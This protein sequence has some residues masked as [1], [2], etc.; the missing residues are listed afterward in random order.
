LLAWAT[1]PI[2]SLLSKA[3]ANV[4]RSS[5]A[6]KLDAR[7]GDV[8]PA[9][10]L[11]SPERSAAPSLPSEPPP[12]IETAEE[13]Q[14]KHD[15]IV[16]IVEYLL[17]ACLAQDRL[18]HAIGYKAAGD[19]DLLKRVIGAG[20]LC[21]PTLSDFKNTLRELQMAAL[22]NTLQTLDLDR[23]MDLLVE[24]RFH[25][26]NFFLRALGL[27]S[28]WDERSHHGVEKELRTWQTNHNFLV[29]KY[30]DLVRCGAAGAGSSILDCG[31]SP[32]SAIP[33]ILAIR[34]HPLSAVPG[35][36]GDPRSSA[37]S[38]SRSG[39]KKR[40]PHRWNGRATA[41]KTVRKCVQG[42]VAGGAA[43]SQPRTRDGGSRGGTPPRRVEPAWRRNLGLARPI[44]G[45]LGCP[46]QKGPPRRAA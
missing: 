22:S 23:L 46:S 14:A 10:R 13:R 33:V 27:M 2:S 35:T 16:F 38:S 39:A 42:S 3:R 32:A 6:P 8:A 17:P 29:D 4:S 19:S 31:W 25:Y 18:Q 43:T 41:D 34:Q 37:P 15:L 26:R 36:F 12:K 40:P 1:V 9:R 5:E 24:I 11:P 20:L 44:L 28:K 45:V 21:E 7:H 30:N